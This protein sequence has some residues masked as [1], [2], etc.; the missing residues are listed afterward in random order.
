M[1]VR[2]IIYMLVAL[3]INLTCWYFVVCFCAT[4]PNSSENWIKGIYLSMIIDYLG[5]KLGVPLIKASIRLL[6]RH[7][8]SKLL[9]K[10][11]QI[12]VKIMA[13]MKPKRI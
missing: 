1:K 2:F 12:W 6:I 13:Y 4:Y 7:T 8:K 10:I 3:I 5:I 9:I 11:Y